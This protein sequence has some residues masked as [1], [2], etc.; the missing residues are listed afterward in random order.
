M[1]PERWTMSRARVLSF[2]EIIARE[3]LES[4]PRK[5]RASSIHPIEGANRPGSKQKRFE[6]DLGER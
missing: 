2:V 6:P 3:S 4:F 5:H 1:L